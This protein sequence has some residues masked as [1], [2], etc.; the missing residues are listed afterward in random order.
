MSD[1]PGEGEIILAD[2]QLNFD[3][4]KGD[5]LLIS[6]PLQFIDFPFLVCDI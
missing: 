5:T 3:V 4:N 1:Q 2:H 6:L